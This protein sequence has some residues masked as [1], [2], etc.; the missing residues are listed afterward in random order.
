MADLHEIRGITDLQALTLGDPDVRIAVLDG[1]AQMEHEALQGSRVTLL[2]PTGLARHGSDDGFDAHATFV[3]SVLFGLPDG[4]VPGVAPGCTGYLIVAGSDVESLD[5]DI[6]LVRAIEQALELGVQIVHCAP[7]LTSQSGMLGDLVTRAFDRLRD[8]GVLVVNP[9]AN[10]HGTTWGFPAIRDDVLAVGSVDD[11]GHPA[12]ST[13][14]GSRYE[15]HGVMANGTRIFGA[16]LGGGTERQRGT[17]CAAPIVTGVAALLLSRMR[18]LG[19]EVDPFE[20]G[21]AIIA[22]GDP[23]TGADAERSVGGVLDPMAALALLEQGA[24]PAP[25]GPRSLRVRDVPVDDPLPPTSPIRLNRP[26]VPGLEDSIEPV[27]NQGDETDDGAEQSLLLPASVFALGRIAHEVPS[28]VV[29]VALLGRMAEVGIP[30]TPDDPGSM[31]Q[32]IAAQPETARSVTWIAWI[33]DAPA[34]V[35]APVGPLAAELLTSYG[36]ALAAQEDGSIDVLSL[37]GVRTKATRTLRDGMVLP[38]LTMPAVRGMY[39]WRRDSQAERLALQGQQAGDFDALA[40]AAMRAASRDGIGGPTRALNYLMANPVQAGWSI[41][42]AHEAGLVFR[43]LRTRRS[44][45][46]RPF[47]DCWD[48]E[49]TFYDPDDEWRAP[50]VHRHAIDVADLLPVSIG[51]P[52]VW[53]TMPG[54]DG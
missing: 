53:R 22:S 31:A 42:R 39:A 50:E 45:L 6:P 10:D 13:N 47:S 19:R 38:T 37:P 32:L 28:D 4:L 52:V 18:E 12:G 44:R 11:D 41:T 40:A 34:Y 7:S 3:A 54:S 5:T 2:D 48:I 15:G 20:V 24:V 36:E 35:L 51:R 26:E 43:S 27:G 33:D 8:A 14:F 30:G 29:R 1:P 16:K 9:V 46:S 25:F 23:L 49:L 21:R 17:S